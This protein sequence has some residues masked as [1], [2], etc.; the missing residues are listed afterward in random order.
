MSGG[1]VKVKTE[2][3]IQPFSLRAKASLS[4]KRSDGVRISLDSVDTHTLTHTH[5]FVLRID[6]RC[7]NAHVGLS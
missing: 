3:E 4:A 7:V 1:P 5:R 2:T 6:R